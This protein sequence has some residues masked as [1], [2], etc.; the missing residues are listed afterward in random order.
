M[1]KLCFIDVETTG[2]DP[3]K[4]GII[5]IAG[6]IVFGLN[7]VYTV[8]ETFNFTLQ[9]FVFDEI[10]AKALEVNGKTEE[11]IFSYKE[12]KEILTSLIAILN[13]HVDK[14][15]PNDRYFFTGYKA[16]FDYDF[17]KEWF[18]KNQNR[19]FMKYFYFPALDVLQLAL[20]NLKS[21]RASMPNFKLGTVAKHLNIS[22]EGNLHD[23]KTDVLLTK[24]I[25]MHYNQVRGEQNEM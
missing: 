3:K 19:D 13:R 14:Y 18:V 15:N 21:E 4:N 22:A 8:I 5:Q 1:H 12:P 17:M 24:G 25:F 7:A 11:Q 23:A 2:L 6:E 9:P 20:F 16:D 10:N